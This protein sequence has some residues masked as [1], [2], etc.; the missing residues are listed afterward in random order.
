VSVVV[1]R[2]PDVVHMVTS[3]MVLPDQHTWAAT[4]A[5]WSS[6]CCCGYCFFWILN[7]YVREVGTTRW[8]SC[9]SLD[10][11]WNLTGN[12]IPVC[13]LAECRDSGF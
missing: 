10:I 1:L 7:V 13:V 9:P 6:R 11:D 8:P 5:F 4:P 12:E 2:G 3:L